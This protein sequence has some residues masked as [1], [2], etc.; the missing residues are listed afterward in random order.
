MLR[1][2][3]MAE[4]HLRI[5]NR[6]VKWFRTKG[7]SKQKD[8]EKVPRNPMTGWRL[9]LF[10]VIAVAV[11]PTLFFLLLE[12]ALRI[13]GYGFP[14]AAIITCKVGGKD[15]CCDNI[16]FGWRFFSRN[17]AREFA[18]FVF[19]ADKPDNTYRIFVIGSSAAKGDPD[20]AFCF[21]RFLRVMLREEYP[22][23]NFEVINTAMPAINSHAILEIA[24]GCARHEPD[25]FIGYFGNNE[26]TGPYGPGTIFS[27]F[28]ASLSLIRLG[29]ALKATKL[30]QLLTDLLEFAG[31]QNNTTKVWGGL[32]MFL[33]KQVRA[34]DPR[35]E[36]VYQHFQRN[37]EDIN[38]I[39][40]KGGAKTILCTVGS[41]LKD[42]P[43][44]ASL[45]REDITETEEK[46]WNEIYQEGVAYETTEKYAEAVESYL[47]AAKIDDCYADLQF[48]LGRC[49]WAMGEYDRARER[50]IRARELDTLR[51]RADNRINE[52]IHAVAGNRT[53]EGVYLVDAVEVFE[54]NSPYKTTG[55]DLFYEHVHL[56]FKGNYLLAKTIF[57]QVE[58]ILPERI[59]NRRAN[60][61]PLLT[62][63]ECAERLAYNDWIRYN[64]AFSILTWYIKE[65]PFTNQLYH[66]EQVK[67][68]EQ[69]LKGLKV[70][71]TPDALE[72]LAAVYRQA[73]E[74]E[75]S[76]W[77]LHER[78]A[79]FLSEGLKDDLAAV[80]QYR[81]VSELLPHSYR[82]HL[83]LA[84]LLGRQGHFD[85]GIDHALKTLRIKPNC[86]YAYHY[87]GSVHQEQGQIDEAIKCYSTAVRLQPDYIEAYNNLGGMLAQQGNLDKAVET[88]RKGLLFAPNDLDLHYNL[89]F[90]LG[91]LGRTDEAIKELRAS[92]QIDPNFIATRKL[93]EALAEKRD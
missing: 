53:V 75:P 12:I 59:K 28:S 34:D 66:G 32:E 60:K 16:K 78:Y 69:K 74:N 18:P 23:V 64:I 87:L 4:S 54:E 33:G 73:I 9:W 13:V 29:I 65:P 39:A 5:L 91:K 47:A 88:C 1:A 3:K 45:H 92:L 85:E 44:F 31:A 67:Q 68:M 22:G 20:S 83:A 72:K 30:G 51:F 79:V 37:L 19:P 52:I 81:L 40:R 84:T 25:L 43:P 48:R 89:G 35:L 58:E 80:E 11:I 27:S 2:Q 49:Y 10:R 82:P 15:A 61:S 63:A 41:N 8:I 77:W 50:Y 42:C 36:T 76:D 24:K 71:L 21:G 93:L 46:K 17:I 14:V 90:L 56:N 57:K 7:E 62:E 26:V 70:S 6:A 55:E 86:A 38:R